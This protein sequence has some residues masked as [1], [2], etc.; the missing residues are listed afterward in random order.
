MSRQGAKIAR[1]Q[2]I[3]NSPSQSALGRRVFIVP[4]C[5]ALEGK[6]GNRLTRKAQVRSSGSVQI[7]NISES[8]RQASRTRSALNKRIGV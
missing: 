4:F 3:K 5:L 7:A 1:Q 6:A 2:A 8:T